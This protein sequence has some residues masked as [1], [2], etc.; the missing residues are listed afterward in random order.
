MQMSGVH[1]PRGGSTPLAPYDLP[2]QI[3]NRFPYPAPQEKSTWLSAQA[4]E[5]NV[6]ASQ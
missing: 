3:G 1:L 4:D 5:N 2:R 6:I